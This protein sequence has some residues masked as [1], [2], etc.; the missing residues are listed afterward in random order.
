MERSLLLFASNFYR[1]FV[2]PL[3]EISVFENSIVTLSIR[4]KL[5]LSSIFPSNTKCVFV[6]RNIDRVLVS[7]KY[8]KGDI[9]STG[10]TRLTLRLNSTFDTLNGRGGGIS[11]K[12]STSI[13]QFLSIYRRKHVWREFNHNSE[14]FSIFWFNFFFFER[15]C[16]YL[17]VRDNGRERW[18]MIFSW[19]DQFI[20]NFQSKSSNLRDSIRN[21]WCKMLIYNNLFEETA[22]I[23]VTFWNKCNKWRKIMRSKNWSKNKI[24]F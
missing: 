24:R 14:Y 10:E 11:M 16:Y 5:F 12:F 15:R 21:N 4:R 8:Q 23:E 3:E 6:Q 20:L 9:D 17:I 7:G 22:I 18:S 2:S 1:R 13:G 19:N